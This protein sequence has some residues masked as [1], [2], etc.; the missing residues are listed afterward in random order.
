MRPVQ[1]SDLSSQ[2]VVAVL[3]AAC[4]H[5]VA[6]HHVATSRHVEGNGNVLHDDQA[7]LSLVVFHPSL[8]L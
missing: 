6:V 3:R 8:V 4:K 2:F 7:I 5:L 1:D